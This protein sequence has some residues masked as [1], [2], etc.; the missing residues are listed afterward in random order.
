MG[1]AWGNFIGAVCVNV[2]VECMSA[3][4]I[5]V[6]GWLSSKSVLRV[7]CHGDIWVSHEAIWRHVAATSHLTAKCSQEPQQ[8]LRV[9]LLSAG[10]GLV[11]QAL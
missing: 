8:A 3:P 10:H 4:S 2:C 5:S 6:R 9:P 1:R 7:L 11:V